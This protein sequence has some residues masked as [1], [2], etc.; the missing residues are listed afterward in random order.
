[1]KLRNYKNGRGCIV[2]TE[3]SRV[4]RRTVKVVKHNVQSR[5]VFTKVFGSLH[6]EAS[7]RDFRTINKYKSLEGFL[8]NVKTKDL[9][10]EII[11]LKNKLVNFLVEELQL[12][13]I[14]SLLS[15]ANSEK[16]I[17]TQMLD[18][19][20]SLYTTASIS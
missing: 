20:D 10:M 3:R 15:K 7:I 16:G 6:I 17:K 11:K 13:N 19:I 18:Y 9:S 1:M 2:A 8:L 14:E 5:T 4:T 12:T